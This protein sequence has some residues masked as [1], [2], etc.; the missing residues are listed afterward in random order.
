MP[1]VNKQI[2]Y[3]TDQRILSIEQ[4]RTGGATLEGV[5]QDEMGVGGAGSTG[6]GTGGSGATATACHTSAQGFIRFT[7]HYVN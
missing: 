3:K 4:D 1:L 6:A 5:G 2:H 7:L